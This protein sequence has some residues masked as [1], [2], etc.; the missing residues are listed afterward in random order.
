MRTEGLLRFIS[1]RL[2]EFLHRFAFTLPPD[3]RELLWELVPGI[4]ASGSLRLSEIAR[5]RIAGSSELK[6]L[7]KH[8]SCQLASVHWDHQPLAETLLADQARDVQEDSIIAIDFSELVKVY[9]R[10]LQYLD[11]V[12]DRSD[13]DKPIRPGYWLFQAYRVVNTDQVFPLYLRLFSNRQPRFKGQ[14]VLFDEEVFHLR[15]VLN[16]RGIWTHDRGFDGWNYLRP[17]LTY[18]PPRWIVRMRGDRNLMDRRGR[19]QS[20]RSWADQIRRELP[21]HRM[22]GGLTVRLPCDKRWLRRVTCRFH[23][24][25]EAEPWMLLTKGFDQVPYTP[26]KALSGYVRR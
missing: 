13:P 14:T 8:W 19:C 17:L 23:V 9:G 18:E 1:V 7:E 15:R 21:E 22:A 12:S 20:V 11:Q 5:T 26:R 3:R 24:P 2:N 4:L 25:T 10:K 6:P 16:G